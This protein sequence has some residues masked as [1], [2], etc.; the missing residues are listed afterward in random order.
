MS[1]CDLHD[2]ISFL[3]EIKRTDVADESL[4]IVSDSRRI[5]LRYNPLTDEM[6]HDGLPGG[7]SPAITNAYHIV[8]QA[9]ILLYAHE[10]TLIM[11][12][13]IWRNRRVRQ[14]SSLRCHDL[15]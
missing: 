11:P 3:L 8:T 5:N 9:S 14:V 13:G 6:T 4:Q 10:P 12:I 7:S 15:E 2:L 1:S